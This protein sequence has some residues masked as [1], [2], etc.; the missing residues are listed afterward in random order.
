MINK[1]P[2][3]GIPS[4]PPSPLGFFVQ[5]LDL[6]DRKPEGGL[7]EFVVSDGRPTATTLLLLCLL[8]VGLYNGSPKQ[9]QVCIAKDRQVW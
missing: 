2:E 3:H 4:Y 5:P 9:H 7:H 1:M 6:L 8:H